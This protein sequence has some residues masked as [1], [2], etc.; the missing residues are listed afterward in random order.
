MIAEEVGL[1]AAF[2][3][4]L[5]SFL[6]PCVLPLVPAYLS[7]VT[8]LTLEELGEEGSQTRI[9]VYC[10]LFVLGFSVVFVAM[11]A[12]A[13]TVGRLLIQYRRTINIVLGLVVVVM[14]L[15]IAGAVDI[16]ALYRERRIHFRKGLLSSLGPIATALMGSAFALGWT[17][18]V[19]P[20]LSSILVY[21][22]AS[23]SVSKGVVLLSFY[24][25]GLGLPFLVTGLFF[26]RVI[27]ALEW[28]KSNQRKINTV[29]GGLLVLMGILLISD[30]LNLFSLPL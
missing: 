19:G 23:N 5:L 6:S 4:G 25:A 27:G 8:G 18:C 9:L 16:S 14:G 2:A 11:G 20:I 10:L 13:S 17:P 28:V 12:T 15:F 3:A 7:M 30:S 29:A 24:S 1:V 26:S 22:A 21:A